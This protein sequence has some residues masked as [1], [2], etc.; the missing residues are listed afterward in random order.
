MVEIGSEQLRVEIDEF[1][2]QLRSIYDKTENLEYLWQRDAEIWASSAPVVFPVIGK[3]NHLECRIDGKRY[4]MKS[5]GILR[6]RMIPVLWQKKDSV[7]FM[8]RADE[9]S[10]K[11]YPYQCSVRLRYTVTGKKLTV[12]A[13][14]CN[15]DEKTMYYNYAG[16]PGFRVPLFE[17]ETCNDYY[18]EFEKKEELEV[19]EVCES[20]QLVDQ[21]IPF[22]TDENKFFIRKHLFRKEALAFHHPCSKAISI[23]SLYHAHK[24]T[25]RWDEFD[26]LAIW[27]PY[28]DEQDVRFICVEPWVGHTDFKGYEGEF[29]QR[30]EIAS[31][32]AGEKRNH[33]YSIEIG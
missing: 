13:C 21:T 27:T 26:N 33:T 20:G 14:I 17:G 3:L 31:L 6:Y 5:N 12:S 8:F 7:E 32:R 19:F 1:G 15:E 22:F 9:T 11:Q 16:H 24:I 29:S 2:A 4:S 30:D 25:V 23:N 28:I 10:K 18:I